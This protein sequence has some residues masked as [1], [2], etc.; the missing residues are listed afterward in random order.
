M[1]TAR[2]RRWSCDQRPET[3]QRH[4]SLVPEATGSLD[5]L[6]EVRAPIPGTG[7]PIL[8]RNRSLSLA[9]MPS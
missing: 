1:E 5:D 6:S 7:L 9:G 2:P 8:V 3:K 4:Q